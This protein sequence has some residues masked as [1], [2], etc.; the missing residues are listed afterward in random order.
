MV[1]MNKPW[2]GVPTRY[3]EKSETLGQIRHYLDAIL[4]AGG[5]P[6][7]IPSICGPEEIRP[8]VD[9]IDGILLPGSPTDIDPARY[10]AEPHP[11]L[12]K[13]FPEREN[14]DFALL[15]CS[16]RLD[17]PLMG[18]CFGVQSLNVYRGGSLVQDITAQVSNAMEHNDSV[19]HP[20]R[21]AANSLLGRLAARDEVEV[22]SDHHQSV[23]S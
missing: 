21:V 17:L 20:V 1:K 7:L 14:I 22:V 9:L 13:V 23:A 10:G 6:L 5:L 4:W 2:I 3:H 12:G 19:R 18:I 8:F 16:E 15:A 11:K